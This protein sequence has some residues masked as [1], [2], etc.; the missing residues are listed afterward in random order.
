[1]KDF[2]IEHAAGGVD[3]TII[4]KF[5]AI[6]RNKTLEIRFYWAGKGTTALPRRGTYGPLISAISIESGELV[7]SSFDMEPFT[8]TFDMD[9]P[10]YILLLL[11][12]E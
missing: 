12:S 2:D 9:M 7:P 1:M 3:K 11:C 10:F 5:K 8:L 4:K 6:V